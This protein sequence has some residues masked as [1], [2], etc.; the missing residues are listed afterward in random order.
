M[1]SPIPHKLWQRNVLAM[2]V[3]VSRYR[4]QSGR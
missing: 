3:V 4:D 2:V 1:K